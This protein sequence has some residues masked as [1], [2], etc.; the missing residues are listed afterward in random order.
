MTMKTANF[1][2]RMETGRKEQAEAL[3]RTLGMTLPQAVNMF[4]AQSLLVGGLP[5]ESRVPQYS[6]ETEEAF[7]EAREIV[8]GRRAAKSYHSAEELFSELD[9]E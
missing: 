8:S 4:I 1:N 6:R 9:A 3:F 2:M 7:Q 5:F